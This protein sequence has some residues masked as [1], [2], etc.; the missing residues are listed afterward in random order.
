MTGYMVKPTCD[1]ER[2]HANSSSR[3]SIPRFLDLHFAPPTNS[4]FVEIPC[5]S[6]SSAGLPGARSNA[7]WPTNGT[8]SRVDQMVLRGDLVAT[9]AN[10]DRQVRTAP[11]RTRPLGVNDILRWPGIFG[12]QTVD[13]P[14][15]RRRCWNSR[16]RSQVSPPPVPGGSQAGHPAIADQIARVW[17]IVASVG[18]R[19]PEAL[20]LFTDKPASVC[21]EALGNSSEERI[22]QEVAVFA[23]RIDVAE[24]LSRLAHLDEKWI[25]FSKGRRRLREAPRLPHAGTQPRSQYPGSKS[26]VTEVSQAS[27][28]LKLLIEQMRE[29]SEFR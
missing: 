21:R 11:A 8:A 12:D 20:A 15:W 5:G 25:A 3:A 17:E 4:R 23:T 16:K 24:E 6:S 13:F 18:P 19:I 1:V 29:Q 28:E 9:L 14:P 10:L 2:G 27:M 26:A 22:L 7:A